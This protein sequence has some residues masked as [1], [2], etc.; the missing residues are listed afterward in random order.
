MVTANIDGDIVTKIGHIWLDVYGYPKFSIG[1]GE[2]YH[3]HRYV[4]EQAI[5]RKLKNRESV[6]HL[7]YDKS[8]C[9]RQNLIVCPDDSY[10]RLLHARTDVLLDGYHPDV[11]AYC[12]GCKTYHPKQEFPKSKLRWNGVHNMCKTT[13]NEYRRAK[14]YSKFDWK[15][16][17]NQQFHR[18]NKKNLVSCLDKEGSRL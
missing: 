12:S 7:N 14:K 10:H 8:D 2:D 17:M 6:H 11:D 15:E 4:A 18:A 5:G 16:R 13:S 1:N 9:R 3:V